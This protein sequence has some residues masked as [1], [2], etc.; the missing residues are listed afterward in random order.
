MTTKLGF[1]RGLKRNEIH[2]S[3]CQ[4]FWNSDEQPSGHEGQI[5]RKEKMFKR[6]YYKQHF[7][8]MYE[9]Q[10]PVI[11]SANIGAVKTYLK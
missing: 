6:P 1:R 2:E 8:L 3:P 11:N 10:Y 9:R 7:L 4:M 5:Y